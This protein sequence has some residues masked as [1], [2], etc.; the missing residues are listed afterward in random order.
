MAQIRT[1]FSRKLHVAFGVMLL[2]TL[3]L[4]W[5]F[6]DSVKWYQYD[7]QRIAMANNV[8]Q[9][10]QEVA[11]LTFR[12]LNDLGEAVD[13]GQ[14]VGGD[15]AEQSREALRLAISEVRQ[16]IASEAAF[17]ADASEGQELE[18]LVEI[19]R[20][21]EEVI[22]AGA[23]IRQSLAE[24]AN[25]AAEEELRR[26]RTSGLAGHFNNLVAGT[27]EEQ[28]LDARGAGSEAIQL[29][30]YITRVLPLV[31]AVLAVIT[32][33]T[34]YFFSRSL[35]RS[36][37]ALREGAMA[38]TSGDLSH[39]IPKLQEAEFVRLGKAF[40]T[41]ARE[42]AVHRAELHN[43]N[44]RLESIVEERTR[45]L[46]ESNRKLAAMDANRRRLLADI[47][48]EL[49]TP[50]TV[51]R[52]ESEISLRGEGKP[53]ADYR[54]AFQRILDQADH[55]TRLVDD[56]LFISRA[57]SGEPRLQLRSVEIEKLLRSVCNDFGARAKQKNVTIDYPAADRKAIVQGDA[58]RLRQVF[59]ILLDNALRYSNPGDTVQ[60]ELARSD[61]EVEVTFRDDGIGLTPEE[62]Q[63]AFERFYRGSN[64]E[65]HANGTGLGLPV[66]KAIVEAHQGQISLEGKLGKGATA[67]VL[68]PCTDKLRIVA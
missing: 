7:V 21:V 31:M 12:E 19:E 15:T 5:Y 42:L 67:R 66:A 13:R 56:L 1:R 45:A 60:V 2:I 29:A 16:G 41:M 9:A 50:L 48:H 53:A 35:T 58:G 36:V 39:R 17:N 46:R 30:D 23:A 54:E 40:N 37:N 57:D 34:I 55:T 52:G 47:S 49:R 44:A 43:A 28:R 14:P 10:Y 65:R 18:T 4:A 63:Q 33:L 24:G 68:L 22:R 3:C 6:L 27:L 38:F 26:L 62:A 51:I 61:S 20:L 11:K 32:L 8:L 59:N 25:R 64:A